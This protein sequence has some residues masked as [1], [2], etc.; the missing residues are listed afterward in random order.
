[1]GRSNFHKICAAGQGGR[2]R[3]NLGV[4]PAL[5]RSPTKRDRA[6]YAA[7]QT[8]ASCASGTISANASDVI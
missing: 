4:P 8:T 1:M 6:S 3:A 7:L 2:Q 5:D